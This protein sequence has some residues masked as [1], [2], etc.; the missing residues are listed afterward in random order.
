VLGIAKGI[1]VIAMALGGIVATLAGKLV[2]IVETIHNLGFLGALKKLKL[3]IQL[4]FHS[5]ATG[6]VGAVEGAAGG[7]VGAVAN[8]ISGIKNLVNFILTTE[9]PLGRV[10]DFIFGIVKTIKT[11]GGIVLGFIQGLLSGLANT[12]PVFLLVGAS[13]IAMIAMLSSIVKAITAFGGALDK[14]TSAFGELAKIPSQITGTLQ[15]MAK[16]AEIMAKAEL[17]KQTVALIIAFAGALVVLAAAAAIITK[18]IPYPEDFLNVCAG[19]A[20]MGATIVAVVGL[21]NLIKSKAESLKVAVDKV[22][23]AFQSITAIGK[24]FA[25]DVAKSILI[26]DSHL[27]NIKLISVT[28]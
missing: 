25:K 22:D 28:F 11:N 12:K 26:K 13:M 7:I 17:R 18:M 4:F 19:I 23:N 16:S 14:L 24:Q 9:G 20:L 6:A 27:L 10:R 5:I 21:V 2:S 1:G 8:A 15:E 3:E